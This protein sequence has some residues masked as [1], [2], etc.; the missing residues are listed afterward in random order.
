MWGKKLIEKCVHRKHK[1][2]STENYNPNK[3]IQYTLKQTKTNFIKLNSL[4]PRKNMP[5]RIFTILDHH[6]MTNIG[7]CNKQIC[8]KVLSLLTNTRLAN[9]EILL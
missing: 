2:F 5:L 9:K 7:E 4:D 6:K 8:C 1:I 3:E